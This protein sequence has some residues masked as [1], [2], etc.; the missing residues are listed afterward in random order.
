MNKETHII[1]P[2]YAPEMILEILEEFNLKDKDEKIYEEINNSS[3][4]KTVAILKNDL[5][6][7]KIASIARRIKEEGLSDEEASLIISE[8]L[9]LSQEE[10]E[11]ALNRILKKLVAFSKIVQYEKDKS[12]ELEDNSVVK[13]SLATEEN[14]DKPPS[15]SKD[16]DVYREPIE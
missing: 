7:I 11:K 16:S 12:K 13:K 1:L 3:D 14:K 9:G 6:S 4:P 8:Q 15:G 5:P 10:A 2:D